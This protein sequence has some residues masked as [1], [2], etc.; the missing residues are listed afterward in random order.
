MGHPHNHYNDLLVLLSLT[1][2]FL[3]CFTALDLAERM[4]RGAKGQLYMLLISVVLGTG[5]WTM[6]FIGM[7]AMDFGV[8]VSYD[9]P[10]LAFSLVIPVAA[11]YMLFVMLNNPHTRSRIYLGLGGLL[12]SSGILIMH[13]SGI[14]AMK[15]A[16][17]YEQGIGSM[18]LSVLFALIVPAVTASYNEQWLRNKYNMFSFSKILLVLLL[19]GAFAGIHYA[20][21]AGAAFTPDV[22]VSYTGQSLLMDDSQ[23]GLLLGGA[24]LFIVA[25]TLGLLYRD[26]QRVL[27]SAEFNEQRYIALFEHN[28]DMVLCIDP[29][30]HRVVSINPA[31]RNTTGYSRED[32]GNYKHILYSDRDA[33]A[34]HEAVLQASRGQS[35]KLELK[36]RTKGGEQMICSATVF[37][38]LHG[39]EH[40]VYIV[41]EDVTAQMAN[42]QELITARDAAESAARMKS[43]FLATMSHEIRTPLNGIIG[44]NQLLAEEISRPEHLELLKLQSS[45]SHALL[46]VMS[47]VLDISRLEADSLVLHKAPFDLKVLLQE[48]IDMYAVVT[49]DKQLALALEIEEDLPAGFVG[50]SARIRQILINLIGNAV[51]FTPS[52]TVTVTVESYGIRGATQGLQFTVQDTGIGIQPDKLQLLFQSF[53]QMD[54]TH[55]RKYPGTGL[56]LAICKKLVDLMQ[57]AIWAEPAEGGGSRFLFRIMLQSLEQPA[58]LIFTQEKKSGFP[59]DNAAV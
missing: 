40:L 37:P 19:T 26:R 2:A 17:T 28:P 20:A 52:G 15:L 23:L 56:G 50:D 10:L 42:Q 21:M 24:F 34:I 3:S 35:S 54:A 11:S 22:S 6:H 59:A 41:A 25:A 57:G 48:C 46:H 51:K 53:S 12:F 36:V 31:L 5:M 58:E 9:L 30:R 47:D 32:L 16:A 14:L 55:T 27:H 39:K 8:P 33:A 4:L 44:I 43:E 1:I 45:S 38:L 49:R 7:R 29:V 13:F 18:I